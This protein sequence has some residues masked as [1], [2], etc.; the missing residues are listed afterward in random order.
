MKTIDLTIEQASIEDIFHLAEQQNLFVRTP[1]GKVFIVAEVE[2]EDEK[3][4]FSHEIAL[5]RQNAALRELLAE[6]SKEPGS[7]TLDQ[8][9]QKLGLPARS[10]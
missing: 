2:A 3:D 1:N 6:R 10:E 8:V 9:R 5:T 7:Y 4:D